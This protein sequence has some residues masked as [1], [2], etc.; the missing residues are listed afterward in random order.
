MLLIQLLGGEPELPLYNS[1]QDD[2]VP[3]GP[4]VCKAMPRAGIADGLKGICCQGG[5]GRLL[6]ILPV[7]REG[8]REGGLGSRGGREVGNEG[9]KR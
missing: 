1:K 9:G 8:S 5:A 3:L 2:S 6:R 7:G 4:L